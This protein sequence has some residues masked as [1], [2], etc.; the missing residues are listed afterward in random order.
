MKTCKKCGGKLSR[1]EIRDKRCYSCE[2]IALAN[3]IMRGG[4]TDVQ[5]DSNYSQG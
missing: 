3:F 4:D 5:P 2:Y 1:Q